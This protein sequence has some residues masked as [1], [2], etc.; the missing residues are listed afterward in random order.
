M[1]PDYP[2]SEKQGKLTTAQMDPLLEPRP[3]EEFF[4]PTDDPYQLTNLSSNLKYR[5]TLIQLRKVMDEWQ[6]RTGDTT[7]S[8]ENATPDRWD[9]RTG[10]RIYEGSHPPSGIFP[11]QETNAAKLNDSGPR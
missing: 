9:R 2:I 5:E 11:G 10:K 4:E 7:P 6:E 8:L 3:S 1:K